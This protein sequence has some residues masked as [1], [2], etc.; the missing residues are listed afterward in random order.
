MD[1][2]AS[3]TKCIK[4]VL[5][6]NMLTDDPDGDEGNDPD[7]DAGPEVWTSR[8]NNASQRRKRSESPH[9]DEPR[10]AS[11]ATPHRAL[12][13]ASPAM[14]P[15]AMSKKHEIKQQLAKLSDEIE[16]MAGKSEDEGFKQDIYDAMKESS[17][18]STSSSAASKRRKRSPP[19]S[20]P[21]FPARI[22]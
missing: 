6:S 3:A 4:D 11:L 18:T 12:G 10:I 20:P 21:P 8:A 5:D 13:S 15:I 1:H 17:S 16:L 19:I 22:V 2:H 9:G 7:G 14:K